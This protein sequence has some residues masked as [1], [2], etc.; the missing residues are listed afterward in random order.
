MKKLALN[1]DS[2][3]VESFETSAQAQSR[4]G[5]IQAHNYDPDGD[6]HQQLADTFFLPCQVSGGGTCNIGWSCWG[7]C[8]LPQITPVVS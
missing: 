3:S 8:Q 1:I 4:R 7:G 6:E 2:L 5:T